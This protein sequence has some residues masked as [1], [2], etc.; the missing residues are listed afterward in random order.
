MY[1]QWHCFLD[2][3]PIIHQT[4]NL[5]SFWIDIDILMEADS[6]GLPV[7]HTQ[8]FF[9]VSQLKFVSEFKGEKSLVLSILISYC[10]GIH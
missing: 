10:L 8:G 9:L 5:V 2:E 4:L 1:L 3:F 6:P 7:F